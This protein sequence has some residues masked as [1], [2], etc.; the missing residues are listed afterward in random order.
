MNAWPGPDKTLF[1]VYNL[2]PD[3]WNGP[4]FKAKADTT[5]HAVDLWNHEELPTQV[6][7]RQHHCSASPQT[8]SIAAWLGTRRE[9]SVDCIAL[10]PR[11]LSVALDGDSLTRGRGRRHADRCLGR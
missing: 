1:T 4:L 7:T 6:V 2:R 8:A 10:F 5:L 9:G 11:R 3:G